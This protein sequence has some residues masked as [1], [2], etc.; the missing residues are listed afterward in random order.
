MSVPAAHERGLRV[1]GANSEGICDEQFF[2]HAKNLSAGRGWAAENQ[3][4]H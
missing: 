1:R 4:R 2:S 3:Q